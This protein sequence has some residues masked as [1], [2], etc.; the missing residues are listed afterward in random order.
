MPEAE[1]ETL[2]V[3]AEAEAPSILALAHHCL[4][5]TIHEFISLEPEAYGV[6]CPGLGARGGR[7]LQAL[8]LPPSFPKF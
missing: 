4:E 7:R 2:R 6:G 8:K 5:V 3:E 1:S